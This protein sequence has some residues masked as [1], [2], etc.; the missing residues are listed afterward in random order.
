METF[1]K[2]RQIVNKYIKRHSASLV[3]RECKFSLLTYR[4]AIDLYTD[5]VFCDFT[6]PTYNSA[7]IFVNLWDLPCR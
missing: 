4:D 6:K 5:L 1:L 3:S 7:R 2:E